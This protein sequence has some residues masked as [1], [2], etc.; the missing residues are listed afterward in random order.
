MSEGQV[1]HAERAEP[2]YPSDT[3]P[4]LA[5][6]LPH[7]EMIDR[8]G[9][10]H[11]QMDA[12]DDEPGS[13]EYWAFRFPCGL[14]TFIAYHLHSP[15]GSDGVVTASSPDIGHILQHLPIKQWLSWRFDL[16]E[17]DLFRQRYGMASGVCPL[18]A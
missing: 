4:L 11:R 12:E 2:Y 7:A 18:T 13:C 16:A 5:F 8:F 15:K 9:P 3:Q 17:P 10:A 1:F 6:S 14:T